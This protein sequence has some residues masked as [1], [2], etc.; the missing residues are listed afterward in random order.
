MPGLSHFVAETALSLRS[1]GIWPARITA[2]LSAGGHGMPGLFA[3]AR[4]ADEFP[5]ADRHAHF[6]V[7]EGDVERLE[8]VRL[9]DALR[10][11]ELAIG[12]REQPMP[13]KDQ[14]PLALTTLVRDNRRGRD[15]LDEVAAH[16]GPALSARVRFETGTSENLSNLMRR[17][18]KHGPHHD[19]EPCPVTFEYAQSAVPVI[20]EATRARVEVSSLLPIADATLRALR[21]GEG[22][23]RA[24]DVDLGRHLILVTLP[25]NSWDDVRQVEQ[26]V[27]ERL[28]FSGPADRKCVGIF[29]SGYR[30]DPSNRQ[31]HAIALRLGS[32]AG[33]WDGV[34]QAI[35][36][37]S[38][39]AYT[40]PTDRV[41]GAGH[42]GVARAPESI[43]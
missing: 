7:P 31:E 23:N 38:H 42:D 25:S 35:V 22:V 33:G 27:L 4:A 30:P 24:L 43:P 17:L 26:Y 34:F 29:F 2:H 14:L 37:S 39:T 6:I 3:L 36:T 10:F 41:D 8:S 12:V 9:L 40:V 16:I 13:W 18:I 21:F 5:R 32:V 28:E 19:S 20:S 1:A 15:D 11:G